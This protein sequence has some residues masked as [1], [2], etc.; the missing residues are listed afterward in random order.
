MFCLI[1]CYPPLERHWAIGLE[2]RSAKLQTYCRAHQQ[3]LRRSWPVQCVMAVYAMSSTIQSH[4][5]CKTSGAKPVLVSRNYNCVLWIWNRST[6]KHRTFKYTFPCLRC[7]IQAATCCN[8][9]AIYILMFSGIKM[10]G[11]IQKTTG[12]SRIHQYSFMKTAFGANY[13]SYGL[14]QR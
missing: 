11:E 5:P 4:P 9:N 2:L 14:E 3:S 6:L 8:F 10:M 12:D 7:N 1:W 13:K